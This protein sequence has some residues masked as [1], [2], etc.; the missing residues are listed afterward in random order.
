LR[1]TILYYLANSLGYLVVG[2]SNRSELSVGY[3]TKYGDGGVDLIPLGSLVKGQVRELALYLGIPQEIIDKPPSAGL[4]AGQT[5]E[6]ELG[7]TYAQ[8]DR[9][10]LTGEGEEEIKR[11]IGAMITRNAH[12]LLPPSIPSS[13]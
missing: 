4:W 8:L 6:G 11:R 13:E 12:K 2:S 5:N 9:Y 10:L 7:V 1:M 3:F